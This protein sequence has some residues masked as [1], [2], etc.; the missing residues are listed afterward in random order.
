MAATLSLLESL[1]GGVDLVQN[2]NAF[3][4]S[5]L[6]QVEEDVATAETDLEISVAIDVSEIAAIIITSSQDVTFET[7]DGAAPDDTLNLLADVPYVWSETCYFAN[8]LTADITSVFITNASGSTATIKI[9]TVGDA[10]P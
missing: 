1:S 8:L 2:I 7:N 9:L 4:G 6:T 3:S 10:T 5:I